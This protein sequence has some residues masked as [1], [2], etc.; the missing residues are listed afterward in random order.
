MKIEG[1]A[2]PALYDVVVVEKL[3]YLVF[4]RF[5]ITKLCYIPDL[6]LQLVHSIYVYKSILC[7]QSVFEI[8]TLTDEQQ[9]IPPLSLLQ[10]RKRKHVMKY[11]I[12]E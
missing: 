7:T 9:P 10:S 11:N 12:I 8:Q 4:I 5:E 1:V 2:N 6:L 3:C